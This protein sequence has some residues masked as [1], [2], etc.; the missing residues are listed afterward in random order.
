M[1]GYV[2]KQLQC[3]RKK[4]LKFEHLVYSYYFETFSQQLQCLNEGLKFPIKDNFMVQNPKSNLQLCNIKIHKYRI[5]GNLGGKKLWHIWQMTINLPRFYLPILC[6]SVLAHLNS[7]KFISPNVLYLYI[8]QS[9]HLPIFPFI[10]YKKIFV[11]RL[12]LCCVIE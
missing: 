10:W 12:Q 2:T 3:L 4:L 6:Y 11:I 1:M 7:P 9:F 5:E 8:R